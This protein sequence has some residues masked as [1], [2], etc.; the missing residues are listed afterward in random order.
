[1]V[2]R[3][4]R[5]RHWSDP[6]FVLITLAVV[7]VVSAQIM[8]PDAY[9]EH[10]HAIVRTPNGNDYGTDLLK[11]HLATHPHGE[12]GADGKPHWHSQ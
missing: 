8:D 6:V 9:R 11:Q 3:A 7:G 10:V 4:L 2:N 1:M 5:K 12:I